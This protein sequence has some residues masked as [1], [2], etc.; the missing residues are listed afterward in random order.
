MAG[1]RYA[2][3]RAVTCRLTALKSRRA[4]WYTLPPPLS[5]TAA[6]YSDGGRAR[7]RSC[8]QATSDRLELEAVAVSTFPGIG[9][10]ISSGQKS[11]EL[12]AVAR[13]QGGTLWGV[14]AG[15]L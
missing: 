4:F 14:I 9:P 7:E 5:C 8:A 2:E 13:D 11:P 1:G 3:F 6:P 10:F 12:I 15:T